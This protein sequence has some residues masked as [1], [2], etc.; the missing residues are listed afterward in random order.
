V[1]G[2]FDLSAV[3]AEAVTA[4]RTE[5]TGEMCCQ[6]WRSKTAIDTLPF[7]NI[8]RYTMTLGY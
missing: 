1:R 6:G 3:L 2:D 4:R 8:L 5:V 7:H